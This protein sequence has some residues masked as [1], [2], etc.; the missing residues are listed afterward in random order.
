MMK[1]AIYTRVSTKEQAEEGY[2]IDEQERLLV[3]F[4]NNNGY[5]IFKCYSDKGIS[6]KNIKA[7]PA[8]QELMEDAEDKQFS[9]V[10]TW[11]I[12]RLSRS[13]KD[14]LNIMDLFEKNG[15][16][17]KS[18]TE[19]YD[20]STPAGKMLFQVMATVGE[21]ERNT[22]AENVKMGAMARAREGK[23][24]GGSRPFGY[25]LIPVYSGKKR[26][27]K[28]K[29]NPTEAEIVKMIFD[30]HNKGWGYKKIVNELNHRGFKTKRGNEF[31]IAGIREILMNPV[32][33]GKIRYNLRQDWNNKRRA[34]T[35]PN[36]IIADGI[37]EPIIC[38]DTWNKTQTLMKL[39]SKATK[40]YNGFY[41]LTGIL[42]CPCCGSGMVLGGSTQKK[43][44]I[45]YYVC[46]N[47][48][49]KGSAVCHSNSIRCDVANDYVLGKIAELL[50]DDKVV[51]A[52]VRRMNELN[53][54]QKE[55]L[56]KSLERLENEQGRLEKGKSNLFELYDMDLLTKQEFFDRKESLTEKIQ[57]IIVMKEE[58]HQQI[59]KAKDDISVYFVKTVL[60]NFKD[61]L[62]RCKEM[63]ETKLLLQLL[64]KQ[65]TMDDKRKIDSIIIHINNDL[66]QYLHIEDMPKG[67][68]SFCLSQCFDFEMVV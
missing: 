20:N 6:G 8:L 52:V 23:W 45:F 65:V 27:S 67:I 22:I 60:Q 66:L 48:H 42:R 11:K 50:S 51:E 1:V 34:G 57:Q 46:G 13:V 30:Y 3:Q 68:S 55:P 41:P 43:G 56:V 64:I 10:I 2:S 4:C 33:L 36:P 31:H 28:L 5:E 38:E 63:Q 44:R 47:F 16:A 40:T 62:L 58:L 19:P 14:I 35:N 29:I 15:I 17:Y 9:L 37:H 25:D 49:N 54:Q 39:K 12:N 26:D 21:F 24:C 32:Y 59:L 7:R 61:T 53:K 18:Y